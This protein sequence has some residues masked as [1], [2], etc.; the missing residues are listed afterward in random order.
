MPAVVV[1][2]L[3]GFILSLYTIP[4]ETSN[5]SCCFQLLYVIH[6]PMCQSMLCFVC[7]W[8]RQCGCSCLGVLLLVSLL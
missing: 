1:I 4:S 7:W 3:L 8:F 6:I 2:G 5:V